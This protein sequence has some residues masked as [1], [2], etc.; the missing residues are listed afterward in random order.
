MVLAL[1][2]TWWSTGTYRYAD[3]LRKA[4]HDVIV[5]EAYATDVW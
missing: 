1:E 2:N 4:G 5:I 3:K